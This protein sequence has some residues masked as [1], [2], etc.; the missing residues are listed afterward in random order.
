MDKIN[1]YK[2]NDRIKYIYIFIYIDF[3]MS[4]QILVDEALR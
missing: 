1:V 3:D 4:N 2:T